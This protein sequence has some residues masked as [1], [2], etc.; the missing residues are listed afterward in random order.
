M[1]IVL[2]MPHEPWLLHRWRLFANWLWWQWLA[3]RGKRP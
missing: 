3:V 1:P 2:E